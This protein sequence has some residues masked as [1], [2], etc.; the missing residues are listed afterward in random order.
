MRKSQSRPLTIFSLAVS[1]VCASPRAAAAGA[2]SCVEEGCRCYGPGDL[3]KIAG[4]ITDLKKC[5]LELGEKDKLINDRLSNPNS[6]DRPHIEWWQEPSVIIAG[7]AVSA[8]L[9]SVFTLVLVRK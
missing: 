9:A 1:L 7:V 6:G 5:Q 4:A 3:A 8:S 2:Q